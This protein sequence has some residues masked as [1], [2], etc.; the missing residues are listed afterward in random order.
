MCS[1]EMI[2]A[3]QSIAFIALTYSGKSLMLVIE[4]TLCFQTGKNQLL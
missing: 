2:L 4:T 1:N 3:V